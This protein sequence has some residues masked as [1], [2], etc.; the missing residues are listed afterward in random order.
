V[1]K[2]EALLNKIARD[3][4]GLFTLAQAEACGFARRTVTGRAARGLYEQIH[5]GVYGFAGSEATWNRQVIAAVLSVN[6]PSAASHRT[7]AFLW[8]M[9][10][11]CPERIEIVTRR[12]L[13]LMRVPFVV[14]ESKDLVETDIHLVDRIPTT[15]PARTLVDLGASAR[16]GTVARCFDT[17]LRTK[18]VSVEEVDEVVRR[19]A[20]R[21]R[22]GIGI[23]RPLVKERLRWQSVTASSLEDRFRAL[24]D[25]AS[26]P[27]PDG[28]YM[29]TDPSGGFVGRYDFAYVQC[30]TLVELDSERFH[31]DPAS[32]QRDREK[33]TRAQML[34]WTVY[35]FTWQDLTDRPDMII[36]ILASILATCGAD[37]RQNGEG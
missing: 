15:S 16:L 31:M 1:S 2:R 27:V 25:R 9:T 34:G 17:A 13:R 30:K 36:T 4:R 10:D 20:R 24:V 12:H 28:Q 3:Q 14:H 21:G 11:Y 23:I 8:G 22:T 35:R 6:L 19:V 18:V 29:L 37:Q 33:Q 5:P 26:L 32:F 7:A